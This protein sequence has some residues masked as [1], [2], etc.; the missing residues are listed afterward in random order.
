MFIICIHLYHPCTVT[1][2]FFFFL[3]M[4]KMFCFSLHMALGHG[5]KGNKSRRHRQVEMVTSG[6]G[7]DQALFRPKKRPPSLRT[8]TWESFG[9]PSQNWINPFFRHKTTFENIWVKIWCWC[10]VLFCL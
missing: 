9:K 8:R 10:D 1:S 5:V 4:P 2:S 7:T 6:P 3:L